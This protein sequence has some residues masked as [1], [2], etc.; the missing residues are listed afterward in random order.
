MHRFD[1][2]DNKQ[3][4]QRLIRLARLLR[5]AVLF[6]HRRR[7]FDSPDADISIDDQ[8]TLVLTFSKGYLEQHK[9]LAADLQQEQ[10][11]LKKA[12]LNLVINS[13]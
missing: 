10:Y 4:K 13:E 2:I 11:F 7:D 12:S 3:D 8:D 5:L 6:N 9:L 1:T